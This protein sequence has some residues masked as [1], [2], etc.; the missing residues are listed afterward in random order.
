[1]E[2]IDLLLTVIFTVTT[3]WCGYIFN[4]IRKEP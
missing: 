4:K 2:T 3:V 1:M